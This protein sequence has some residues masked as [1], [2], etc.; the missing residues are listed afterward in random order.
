MDTKVKGKVRTKLYP[1][2]AATVI[3]AGDLVALSSGLIIKATATSTKVARAMEAHAAGGPL[4]IE[5]SVGR[6]ELQIDGDAYAVAQNGGEYDI[7]V[8]GSSG[9][10]TL[11]SDATSYKVLMVDPKQTAA[12]GATTNIDVIINKPLDAPADAT[13]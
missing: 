10:I 11:D 5:V 8:D 4:T 9:K 1:I 12:V 7:A 13:E 6:V 2:A 3:Q